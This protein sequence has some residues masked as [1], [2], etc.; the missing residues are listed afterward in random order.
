MWVF[1]AKTKN[2]LIAV[3]VVGPDASQASMSCWVQVAAVRAWVS[4]SQLRNLTVVVLSE[5]G[6]FLR[7]RRAVSLNLVTGRQI[8][9]RAG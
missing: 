1:F 6:P 8:H 5:S 2:V 3:L 9:C 4:C 7:I